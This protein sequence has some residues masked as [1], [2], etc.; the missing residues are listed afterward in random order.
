MAVKLG[1]DNEYDTKET[2]KNDLNY[3]AAIAWEL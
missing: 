1:F 3:Y 2:D